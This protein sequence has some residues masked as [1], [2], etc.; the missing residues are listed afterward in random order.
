MN[1]FTGENRLQQTTNT[2][3]YYKSWIAEPARGSTMVEH[4]TRIPTFEGLNP[5]SPGTWRKMKNAVNYSCKN[6]Y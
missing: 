1:C 6:N 2:L 4:R 3:A 5:A